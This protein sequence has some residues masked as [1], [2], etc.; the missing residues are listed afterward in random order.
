MYYEEESRSNKVDNLYCS[1]LFLNN[2]CP[3]KNLCRNT[4][5]MIHKENVLS[6]RIPIIHDKNEIK[7]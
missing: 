7:M 2:E 4:L 1:L 6:Q 5:I 3:V